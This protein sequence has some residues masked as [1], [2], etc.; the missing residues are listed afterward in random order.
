MFWLIGFDW[1][2]GYGTVGGLMWLVYFFWCE[3]ENLI[4]ETG[5]WR[6][7]SFG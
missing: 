2:E 7:V 1:T 4:G 5:E 6:S 3:G